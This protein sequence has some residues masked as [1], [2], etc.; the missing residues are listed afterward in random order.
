MTRRLWRSLR[1]FGSGVGVALTAYSVLLFIG[2]P[3]AVAAGGCNTSPSADLAITQ[4]SAGNVANGQVQSVT[5]TVTAENEG[6]CNATGVTVTDSFADGGATGLTVQVVSVN[7]SS[8]RCVPAGAVVTCAA[9]KLSGPKDANTNN[10]GNMVMTVLVTGNFYAGAGSPPPLTSVA[11]VAYASDPVP[12]NNTS[13]GAFL[14]DGGDLS[15]AVPGK[16]DAQNTNLH[17]PTGAG[18]AGGAEIEQGV[19]GPA[20]P[21]GVKC[22]GQIVLI[23]SNDIV[24]GGGTSPIQQFVFNVPLVKGGPT[25]ANQVVVLHIPDGGT[26]WQTVAPCT[27]TS[28]PTPDPC[29]ASILKLKTASGVQYFQITVDTLING[30]WVF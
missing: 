27:S 12:G 29:V 28:P 17:V 4:S 5:F 25:G 10:P 8:V 30:R 6:P 16:P 24:N 23:N 7:P 14:I 18:F 20:C 3:A 13:Q 26:Q 9:F 1:I 22:F 2:S 11:N 15:Y 21:T 19:S